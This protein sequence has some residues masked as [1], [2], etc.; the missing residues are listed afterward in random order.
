MGLT[1][2]RFHHVSLDRHAC[3]VLLLGIVTHHNACQNYSILTLYA[4]K[5]LWWPGSLRA[6][7]YTAIPKLH[8][9]EG[10]RVIRGKGTEGRVSL[11]V[12]ELN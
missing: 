4:P 3:L 6:H 7:V 5:I 10:R 1:V 2:L 12:R 11:A 8:L 9:G